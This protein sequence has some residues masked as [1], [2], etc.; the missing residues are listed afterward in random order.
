MLERL[1]TVLLLV[2]IAV[3][4]RFTSLYFARVHASA[5]LLIAPGPAFVETPEQEIP[6]SYIDLFKPHYILAHKGYEHYRISANDNQYAELWEAMK[7]VV[8]EVKNS[9][10]AADPQLQ[11][12]SLNEWQ[13]QLN[14]SYE[15]RFAGTAQLHYWWLTTSKA[16]LQKF[17]EDI[18]FNRLLLP[19]DESCIYLQ[20]TYTG[21]RWKWQWAEARNAS[22]FPPFSRLD[23]KDSQRVL[24]VDPGPEYNL[25][26]GTKIYTPATTVTLPEILAGLPITNDNKADIVRR[27]FGIVPRVNRTESLGNGQV[28]ESYITARQQ[29][30]DLYNSGLLQYSERPADLAPDA[31][32]ATTIEQFEQAFNFVLARGGWPKGAINAGMQPLRASG[33]RTGYRFSFLHLYNGL[34]V[35]DGQQN[36][37]IEVVPGGVREYQRLCYNIIQPGYFQFEVRSLAGALARAQS[38]LTGRSIND[39]YLA[40]YQRPYYLTESSPFQS[41]PMYLYP[42]WTIE[43]EDGERLFV[44]AY[45]LLNDPGLIK[46]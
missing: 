28:K 23:L 8:G 5:P 27:F 4:V 41:E 12:V 21:E 43:L 24:E 42:V 38:E 33:E 37:V 35:I 45:K 30:L 2:L 26:S 14:H 15:Y 6:A 22:L 40:Y 1:K 10:Q 9:G 19:L 39:V 17:P 36:L 16:T 11:T 13:K 20:N 34:P 31:A 25:V 29:V 7:Q 3:G 18:Y 44:H 46:P 32:G